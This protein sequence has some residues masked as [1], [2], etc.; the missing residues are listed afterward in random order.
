[1]GLDAASVAKQYIVTH[2][3]PSHN[4]INLSFLFEPLSDSNFLSFLRFQV[5]T[6]GRAGGLITPY[7]GIVTDTP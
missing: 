1:L 5:M 4:P 2:P 7:K 6:T 3:Q